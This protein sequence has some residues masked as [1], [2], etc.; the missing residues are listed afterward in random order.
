MSAKG[1]AL[2]PSR[3]TG[4]APPDLPTV[5]R[6]SPSTARH[7]PIPS[8]ASTKR[9]R[10]R[11][12]SSSVTDDRSADGT[13]GVHAILAVDRTHEWIEVTT[14]VPEDDPR[15]DSLTRRLMASH[16]YERYAQDMFG[17]VAEGHPDPRRLVH[18][19]N[20]PLGTWPLRKDFAW[21]HADA[22]GI[23]A[24][25]ARQGRGRGYLQDS[26]RP[27]SRRYHR[28]RALPVQRGW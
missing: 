7:L 2:G 6:Q 12:T 18:H 5:R 25:S 26:G 11:S 3:R 27:D 24:V 20:V 4:P 8:I 28:A 14:K 16:W 13:F 22:P 23:G 1:R 9:S 10:F 17:V 21:E 15:Y 19:E